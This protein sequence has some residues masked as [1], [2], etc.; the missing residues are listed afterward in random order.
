LRQPGRPA[1]GRWRLGWGGSRPLVA[2]DNYGG[3]WSGGPSGT[4]PPI[5]L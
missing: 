1:F 2:A 5:A 3:G 4:G